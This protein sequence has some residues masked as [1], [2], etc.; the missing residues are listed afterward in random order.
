ME[1][2][3][4]HVETDIAGDAAL[5]GF[6]QAFEIGAL[7][8]LSARDR[9]AEEGGLDVGFGGHNGRADSMGGGVCR[10]YVPLKEIGFKV[11]QC[12]S[13]FTRTR[14]RRPKP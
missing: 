8:K 10:S 6:V 9:V 5:R 13:P 11:G 4:G 3:R 2:R 12:A 1:R 14:I 7:V